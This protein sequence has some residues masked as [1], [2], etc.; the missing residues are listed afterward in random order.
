MVCLYRLSLN[1]SPLLCSVA[2]IDANSRSQAPVPCAGLRLAGKPARGLGENFWLD[3]TKIAG[4]KKA[5][6]GG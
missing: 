2:Y 6:I 3:L 1:A 4:L 5:S